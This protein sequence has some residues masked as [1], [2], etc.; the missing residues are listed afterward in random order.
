L[1][2][3]L[4]GLR[5]QAV[6]RI[7]TA[8]PARAIGTCSESVAAA[9]GRLRPRR[10]TVAVAPG[11]DPPAEA[12]GAELR[13][14]RSSLGIPDGAFVVGTV[15]RL[16]AW[17]GHHLVLRAIAEL[18]RS[19]VPAFG[20]IVGGGG[21][22]SARRYETR[23]LRTR[24]ELGLEGCVALTGQVANATGY[25]QLMDAYAHAAAPEPFGL[26]IVEAM[27]LGVPVV[28]VAGGGPS[29]IIRHGE[30]GLI[31][32]TDA[33]AEMAGALAELARDDELRGRLASGGR[34][35]YR[36]RFTAERMTRDM[37]WV[38]AGFAR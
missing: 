1:P 6:D 24:A 11:I 21:H 36:E 12:S 19:G 35:R 26:A 23:L 18:R 16:V 25:V 10:P 17:K 32:A 13:E 5:A 27:A 38:L 8:L 2:A 30:S 29:E 33:A 4:G 14:L 34:A 31:V 7:A 37:E 28:A 3:R 20:L 22:R 9:Q 15:G